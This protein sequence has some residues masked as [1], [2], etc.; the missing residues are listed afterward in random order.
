MTFPNRRRKQARPGPL[1]PCHPP[2]R[3]AHASVSY[4][5]PGTLRRLWKRRFR[6]KASRALLFSGCGLLRTCRLR[7]GVRSQGGPAWAE[8]LAEP[9]TSGGRQEDRRI[10]IMEQWNTGTMGWAIGR[11][12][13]Y[14]TIPLFHHSIVIPAGG[15]PLVPGSSRAF[16]ARR[17]SLRSYVRRK[18]P[19]PFQN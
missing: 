17:A 15:G 9:P 5:S 4:A 14:S 10:G 6:G 11:L 16:R 1:P 8:I 18:S 19:G 12:P 3:P 2:R 13:Q 7:S